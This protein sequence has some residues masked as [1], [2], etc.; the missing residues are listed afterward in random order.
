MQPIS[1]LLSELIET[2]PALSYGLKHHLLNLTQVAK[3]LRK[4][5]EVRAKRDVSVSSVLMALSRL[6]R[7]MKRV[8]THLPE[9]T[10]EQLSVY[11][12]L[13]ACTFIKCK[14]VHKA[15]HKIHTALVQR[16]GYITINEGLKEMTV[17]IEEQHTPAIL[18]AL[19]PWITI[20]QERLAAIGI[21]FDTKFAQT[22]GFLATILEHV[23]MQGISVVEIASTY[24]EF[25]VYVEAHQSKLAFDTLF[26]LLGN[27]SKK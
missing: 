14:E 2:N 12:N 16:K 19:R 8:D 13:A 9:F 17:I 10:I 23:R 3:L 4:H 7:T 26:H 1:L 5:L 20:H 18:S 24:T 6:Q 11:P 22:P 21:Q 25:I 27:S 15:I